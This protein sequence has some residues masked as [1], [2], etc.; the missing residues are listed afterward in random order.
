[1]AEQISAAPTR[2]VMVG[3]ITGALSIIV[4]WIIQESAK[5][6]IPAEVSSAFTTL[7]TFLVGYLVPPASDDQVT[8]FPR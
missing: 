8:N 1:M 2:K 6:D 5:I 4:I 7:I 3:G